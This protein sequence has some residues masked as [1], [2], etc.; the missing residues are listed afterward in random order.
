VIPEGAAAASK[1]PC[2]EMRGLDLRFLTPGSTRTVYAGVDASVAEGELVAI[3]GPSGSGKSVLLNLL[4]GNLPDGAQ[5]GGS[6]R[7]FGLEAARGYPA[8]V[9]RRVGVVFQQDALFEDLSIEGNVAFALTGGGRAQRR[10]RVEELLRE[11]GLEG[12]RGAVHQLSGGQRKRLALARTLAAEPELVLFDEPTSGLDP[13][14]ARQIAELIARTH[15]AATPRRTTLVVTHDCEAVLPVAGRVLYVDGERHGLREVTPAEALRLLLEGRT[16]P[17]VLARRRWTPASAAAGA[18]AAAGELLEPLVRFVLEP[19]PSSARQLGLRLREASLGPAGFIALASV[20]VG[21]LATF[22]ALEN[23]PLRGAMDRPVLVGLGKVLV[24]VVAPLCAGVLFAARAG[25]G[26]TA[27]LGHLRYSRQVEALRSFGRPS[28][29]YLQ[30]PLLWACLLALPVLTLASAVFASG[31]SLLVASTIR[32][33]S[34]HAWAAAFSAQLE[35]VDAAWLLLKSLGSG[36]VVG[37]TA[38]RHGLAPKGSA[39]DVSDA[40]TSAIVAGAIGVILWQSLLALLQ[41]G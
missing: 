3:V 11:V 25:A 33:L 12:A 39:E 27:R 20:L 7:I 22:F 16:A 32:P 38:V 26:E 13:A 19:L 28:S 17:P 41:F 18:L 30:A 15:R 2:I 24:A 29:T 31:A 5:V 21:G 6:L 36:L 10:R 40:V 1:V 14:R 9:L 34:P 4:L 8:A 23:N 37:L 35:A